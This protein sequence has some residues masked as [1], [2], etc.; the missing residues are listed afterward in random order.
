MAQVPNFGN[1]TPDDRKITKYLLDE[2][3]TQ[4]QGKAK[5]FNLFGSHRQTGKN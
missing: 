4:N 1:A 5:F 3:H 2:T